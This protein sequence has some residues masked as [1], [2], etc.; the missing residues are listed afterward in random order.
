ML[1]I[2]NVSG[3]TSRRHQPHR[4]LVDLQQEQL[5]VHPAAQV[6]LPNGGRDHPLQQVGARPVLGDPKAPACAKRS[7]H[8]AGCGLAVAPGDDHLAGIAR[9][10]RPSAGCADRSGWPRRPG[11]S[12]RRRPRSTLDAVPA[13]LPAASASARRA[14]ARGGNG[15][16]APARAHSG[17][18]ATHH[19]HLRPPLAA[20][21]G[22]R[23]PSS[24]P[25]PAA[26]RVTGCGGARRP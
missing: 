5:R 12:S 23:R 20:A 22:H 18:A 21:R 19:A 1:V 9:R 10:P 17:G 2:R 26:A 8:P 15:R 6:C 3:C 14:C 24:R 16:S 13:A 11:S 25:P 4:R 7:E